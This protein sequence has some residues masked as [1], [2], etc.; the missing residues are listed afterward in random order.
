MA[1]GKKISQLEQEAHR[2]I[3]LCRKVGF[4]NGEVYSLF[5]DVANLGESRVRQNW[6][7]SFC[8]LSLGFTTC[9]VAFFVAMSILM[10]Y[11]PTEYYI[12]HYGEN[13]AYP[14]LRGIRLLTLPLSTRFDLT[15]L[16]YEECLVEN[17]F[18]KSYHDC[19][20]ICGGIRQFPV[21]HRTDFNDVGS[22]ISDGHLHLVLLKKAVPYDVTSMDYFLRVL[23]EKSSI[24]RPTVRVFSAVNTTIRSLDDILGEDRRNELQENENISLLWQV[25]GS[26][27]LKLF[28]DLSWKPSFVP[29]TAEINPAMFIQVKGVSGKRTT[30]VSRWEVSSV[31]CPSEGHSTVIVFVFPQHMADPFPSPS[32]HLLADLL[33]PC[34]L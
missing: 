13:L 7:R 8:K 27:A 31:V 14:L 25:R 34:Q 9:F 1:A 32:P 6:R 2:L 4:S 15:S 3:K 11:K 28:R 21:A 26:G 23:E 19:S 12:S 20:R 18:F 22:D 33:C 16:Y 5:N 10:A 30:V 17:P 24:L 29:D